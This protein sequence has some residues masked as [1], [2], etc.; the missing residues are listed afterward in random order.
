MP[1]SSGTDSS[2]YC[3]F[4]I[5]FTTCGVSYT[6]L[7]VFLAHI[8]PSASKRKVKMSV[9]N[10]LPVHQVIG[11]HLSHFLLSFRHLYTIAVSMYDYTHLYCTFS[12]SSS[13]NLHYYMARC[14]VGFEIHEAGE[15][16][17]VCKVQ[18]GRSCNGRVSEALCLS[19]SDDQCHPL[20]LMTKDGGKQF[21]LLFTGYFSS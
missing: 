12:S 16:T 14:S 7:F 5:A 13:L 17:A 20:C 15:A 3:H 18:A 2:L 1:S 9:L 8:M 10:N 19:W 4:A 21:V 6:N 11:A